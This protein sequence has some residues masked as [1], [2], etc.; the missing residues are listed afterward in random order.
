MTLSMPMRRK[1]KRN[2]TRSRSLLCL[3][4]WSNALVKRSQL[5]RVRRLFGIMR[6]ILMFSLL[7]TDGLRT[8]GNV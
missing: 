3:Y 2:R 6:E 7:V 5:L 4:I 1:R 8:L